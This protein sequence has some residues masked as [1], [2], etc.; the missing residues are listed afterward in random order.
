MA[1]IIKIQASELKSKKISISKNVK[2]KCNSI[3]IGKNVKISNGVQM[4]GDKIIIKD[5]VI[6]DSNSKITSKIIEIGNKSKICKNCKIVVL[7]KFALGDRS[8]LCTCEIKGRY[9]KIGNDFFSSITRGELLI[10]GGG[11]SFYPE[12]SLVVG[13]RCTIHDVYIN[14]AMPVK[15]GDDVGISHGTKFFTHY[16]WN[17]IFEGNPQKFSGITIDDGC[18]IGAESFFLPGVS[19]GKNCIVGARA[20]VSKSFSSSCMIAGNPARVI[21][22]NY[23]KKI[24][25]KKRVELI[26]GTLGRYTDILQTKGF[27]VKKLDKYGMKIRVKNTKGESTY[28]IHS[29]NPREIQKFTKPIVLTFKKLPGT[30][31]YTE[32]NLSNRTITGSENELTDDLR[33]FLRKM[34]IRIFT[35]RRFRSIPPTIDF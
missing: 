2:I 11:N 14:I 16:F 3:K 15:I 27:I 18:I 9:V 4:Y 22:K 25:S 20:I 6:I 17:S 21:R 35:K 7:E 33:D 30:K 13:D 28:I 32:I 34:G 12:S 5:D 8:D 29:H 26:K 10:I 24:S 1:K 31:N 23:R 19:L